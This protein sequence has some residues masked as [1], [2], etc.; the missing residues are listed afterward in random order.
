MAN[1]QIRTGL[2]SVAAGDGMG[3]FD[4]QLKRTHVL[5]ATSALVF[6]H[7]DGQTTPA[8]LTELLRRKFNVPHNQ[9][10]QLLWLALDELEKANLL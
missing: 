4:P 10:E 5:N 8:Q 2:A 6:Q 1:P 9:A 7:C 3:V